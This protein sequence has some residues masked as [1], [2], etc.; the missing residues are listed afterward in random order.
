MSQDFLLK[1]RYLV[2]LDDFTVTLGL[3]RQLSVTREA[4]CLQFHI[5]KPHHI[6]VDL[7]YKTPLIPLNETLTAPVED[8]V[9]HDDEAIGTDHEE[10][11]ITSL[12]NDFTSAGVAGDGKDAA[13]EFTLISKFANVCSVATEEVQEAAPVKS[14]ILLEYS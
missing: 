3:D 9:P 5:I 8:E 4:R 13:A 2:S 1:G 11:N 6:E 14:V 10:V 12:S 7:E